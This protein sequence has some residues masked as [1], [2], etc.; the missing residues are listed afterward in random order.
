MLEGFFRDCSFITDEIR[1][2]E[3]FKVLFLFRVLFTTKFQP[4][5]ARK[6]FPCLDEPNLKA[7]FNI[8]IIHPQNYHAR[9]NMPGVSV[10][11]SNNRTSTKFN[12]TV[13][14]STYLVC[15]VVSQF[16][17]KYSGAAGK[18]NHFEVYILQIIT[19]LWLIKLTGYF[20]YT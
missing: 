2:F 3:I 8:E 20:I 1:I 6:A 18:D 4:T 19:R 14:M 5:D 10:N 15:Y 17:M 16:E 13:K 12:Q 7:T 9:S 11:I